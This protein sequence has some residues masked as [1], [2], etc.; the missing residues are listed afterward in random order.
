MKFSVKK[1]TLLGILTAFSLIMFV[2]EAQFPVAPIG[3]IKLG[4]ANVVTLITMLFVGRIESGFVLLMR[5]IL[6][7]A[8]YGTFVSF[9]FSVTGGILAW[10][11]MCFFV[12]KLDKNQIWVVSVFGGVFHNLG[13]LT[14]AVFITGTSYVFSIFPYLIISGILTGFF[15]GIVAQKIWFSPLQKYNINKNTKE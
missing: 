2:I 15:T 13:Q 12:Y 4:L 6:A 7:T 10:L 11:A 5:I 3:G 1:I 8:F 9:V 14:A